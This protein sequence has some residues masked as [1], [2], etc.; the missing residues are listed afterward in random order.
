[1]KW[2]RI[3]SGASR[4]ASR[5]IVRG[6]EA[7]HAKL[8]LLPGENNLPV[9]PCEANRSRDAWRQLIAFS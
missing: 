9:G 2:C 1:M 7:G 5:R 6:V 8:S 3:C 4:S